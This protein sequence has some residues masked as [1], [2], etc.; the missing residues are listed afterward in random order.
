MEI[1]L[2]ITEIKMANYADQVVERL[3]KR[4]NGINLESK[5]STIAKLKKL[6]GSLGTKEKNKIL[7]DLIIAL[8][9]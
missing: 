1:D 6:K 5:A 4:I 2:I 3:V 8:E 7:E 9:K